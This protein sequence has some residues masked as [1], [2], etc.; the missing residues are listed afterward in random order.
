MHV[1]QWLTTSALEAQSQKLEG[2]VSEERAST[3]L[4]SS[5]TQSRRQVQPNFVLPDSMTSPLASCTGSGP[6]LPPTPSGL[7]LPALTYHFTHQACRCFCL[8]C[9]SNR[10]CSL[11][12]PCLHAWAISHIEP[13]DGYGPLCPL[14]PQRCQ[15]RPLPA[16]GCS[17]LHQVCR[18]IRRLRLSVSCWQC[19]S[20]TLC[21]A[22]CMPDRLCGTAYGL[23]RACVRSCCA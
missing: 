10:R 19:S 12:C 8:L 14:C 20:S 6:R 9:P 2:S 22:R 13:A 15:G 11:G 4:Q 17:F 21:F 7:A 3:A 1:W 23:M 5:A 18:C 16:C